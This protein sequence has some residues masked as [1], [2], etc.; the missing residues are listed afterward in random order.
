MEFVRWIVSGG[1]MLGVLVV[2]HE[3]GHFLVARLFGVG[4]PKFSI[5]IGPRLFGFKLWDTDFRI[6]ALP[7]GGY[8]QMAGNDP[9]GE[10]DP[11]EQVPPEQDFMRKPIWQRL[12]IML[13]GP[14]MNLALPLVLFTGIYMLGQPQPEARIGTLY[15]YSPA[16]EVG[17]AVGD[18]LTTVAHEPVDVWS[19]LIRVLERHIDEP[20]ALTVTRGERPIDVTLPAGSVQLRPDGQIESTLLGISPNPRSTLVGVPDPKSPAGLAG[21]RT[22][23]AVVSVDGAEVRTWEDLEAAL[24]TAGEHSLVRVRAIDGEVARDTVAVRAPTVA[25][26]AGALAWGFEHPATYVGAVVPESAAQQAGVRVGDRLEAVDGA[27][28]RVWSDVLTLVARTAENAPTSL[29]GSTEPRP[30]RLELT[31]DGERISLDFSPRW[32]REVLPSKVNIRPLMGVGQYAELHVSGEMIRKYY[33]FGEAGTRAVEETG[34][35]FAQ[36]MQM[37]GMLVGAKVKVTEVM[38]GPLAIL[39][40]AGESAKDGIFTFVRMMGMISLSLGIV[41]LLPIPV[42]DGGQILFYAFEGIRGRPLPLVW[43]ERI[44]MVAVLM[45]AALLLV[46]TVNDVSRLFAQPPG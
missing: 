30:L 14:A 4:T 34:A 27:P 44:Q 36:T 41:N 12:L 1:V 13:A 37:L 21:F 25:V 31:R 29:D 15:P 26:A 9:F 40:A 3:F 22:G 28:V 17:L 33:G 19:D 32:E 11:D 46:I 2:I 43:R 24:T 39:Q 6:S 35:L 16:A 23:D 8:V 10:E 42:L 20:I 38:G 7:I 5:G 18:R 45:L